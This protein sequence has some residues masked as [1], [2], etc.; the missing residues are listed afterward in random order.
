MNDKKLF[1]GKEPSIIGNQLVGLIPGGNYAKLLIKKEWDRIFSPTLQKG[2]DTFLKD[3]SQ[4][5]GAV[6]KDIIDRA[7]SMPKFFASSVVTPALSMYE[8][9]P[10]GRSISGQSKDYS[11]LFPNIVKPLLKD[12]K[13]FQSQKKEL[14]NIGSGTV[15]SNTLP[16]AQWALS[17]LS[18]KKGIDKGIELNKN[19]VQPAIRA[20]QGMSPQEQQGGFIKMDESLANNGNLKTVYRSEGG[21]QSGKAAANVFPKNIKGVGVKKS[22]YS[23]VK[24][25]LAEDRAN[26]KPFNINRDVQIGKN[27]LQIKGDKIKVFRFTNG[28]DLRPGDF[29]SPFENVA[30]KF[31]ET[32]PK[33]GRIISKYVPIKELGTTFN[34]YQVYKPTS[35]LGAIERAAIKKYGTTNNDLGKGTKKPYVGTFM[36][37]FKK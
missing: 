34:G 21:D 32:G 37:D 23:N 15:M 31:A 7:K 14:E 29:V 33:N 9:T 2:A 22:V 16:L 4:L 18:A 11:S 25:I 17:V 12:Q 28:D 13:S 36:R 10:Q 20:Y 6:G 26:T 19:Y 3:Y 1:T 5:P 8:S 27:N 30:K 35:S 24:D